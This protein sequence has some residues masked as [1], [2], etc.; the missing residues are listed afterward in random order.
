MEVDSLSGSSLGPRRFLAFGV[1]LFVATACLLLAACFIP[2]TIAE[3]SMAASSRQSVPQ[4]V[5]TT[6]DE[7]GLTQTVA[8]RRLIRPAQ[9]Q[10]A[11]KDNGAAQRLL[12]RLK[13]QSLVKM[14]GEMVAYVNVKGEGVQSVRTGGQLLDFRVDGIAAGGLKLSLD[15]V[16]VLLS[17]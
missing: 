9:V 7:Q 4:I 3:E 10:A 17:R 14:G 13:L 5:E 6:L 16:D 12:E 1:A 2:I 15:G 11:V 8:G